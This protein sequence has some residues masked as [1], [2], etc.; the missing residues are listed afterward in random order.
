MLLQGWLDVREKNLSNQRSEEFFV[1]FQKMISLPTLKK[2][3]T[4]LNSGPSYYIIMNI[5]LINDII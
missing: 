2:Q 1:S 4:V 3:V 5:I